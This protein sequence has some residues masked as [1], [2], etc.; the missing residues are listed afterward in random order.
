MAPVQELTSRGETARGLLQAGCALSQKL[1]K[2]DWRRRRSHIGTHKC[3]CGDG[4]TDPD[5]R[6]AEGA[7]TVDLMHTQSSRFMES[8]ISDHLVK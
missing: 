1:G 6:D 4:R 7:Q 5:R 8:T 3:A 2:A